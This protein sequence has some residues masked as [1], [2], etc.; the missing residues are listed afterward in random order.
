M[1]FTGL[2]V[3]QCLGLGGVDD[4]AD[5]TK[6]WVS[7]RRRK[8]PRQEPY[9]SSQEKLQLLNAALDWVQNEYLPFFERLQDLKEVD[10]EQAEQL[11]TEFY[12]AV[13]QNCG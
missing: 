2:N 11:W 8:A 3:L 6:E 12:L 10:P 4:L 7:K 13:S 9:K 1:R 5:I